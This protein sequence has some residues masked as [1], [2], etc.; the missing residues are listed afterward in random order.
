MRLR[1]TTIF[2]QVASGDDYIITSRGLLGC[3]WRSRLTESD[4]RGDGEVLEGVRRTNAIHVIHAGK[5]TFFWC[6]VLATAAPLN[7]LFQR[8]V[9]VFGLWIRRKEKDK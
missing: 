8:D 9:L 7:G 1:W 6:S 2:P 5:W 4:R 3:N